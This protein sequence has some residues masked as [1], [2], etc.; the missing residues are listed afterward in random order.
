M[1]NITLKDG[2][3]VRYTRAVS[4]AEIAEDIEI[5][6]SKRV[7][8]AKVNDEIIDLNEKITKDSTVEI[9]TYKDKGA[10]KVLRHSTAHVL[11]Q[12]VK[13]LFPDV[14]LAIG[15][16]I[17]EGFYYDF[18]KKEPFKPEDLKRIKKEMRK[19]INE[20]L[21]FEKIELTNAQAVKMFKNE[22]YKLEMIQE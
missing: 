4:A 11:A 13:R 10:R 22:P 6:F 19:I 7:L 12:A 17:E 2:T 18:D 3:K 20:D 21:P 5:G 8:A 9:L 15:P 14:K 16:A 1:V